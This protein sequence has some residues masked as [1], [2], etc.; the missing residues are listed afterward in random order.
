M[1]LKKIVVLSA[2]ATAREVFDLIDYCNKDKEL[3]EPLGYVTDQ[4]HG[5][6]GTIINGKPILGNFEWLE[7]HVDDIY[8][9]C[10]IGPSHQ[11]FQLVKRAEK[12]NCRFI[13]LIHPWTEKY[14]WSQWSSMGQGNMLYGCGVA[15]Q[16]MIGNHV[17]IH[18]LSVI[19]H[20]ITIGDFA[21]ISSGVHIN[22][23]VSIGA[24]CYIGS[25]AIICNTVKIGD[26]A[27][28]GAGSVVTKDIPANAI[29]V[30]NP[31]RIINHKEAG[32]HLQAD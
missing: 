18:G 11:R 10:G 9:I 24:G 1:M 21:T 13:N 28:I 16:T 2:T 6:P 32:W 27:F 12:I 8:V 3:Y 30:G 19:A 23:Y 22:G 5:T 26:W 14:C 7:K 20:N 25:G 15:D 31:A 29:A 17:I 4:Q